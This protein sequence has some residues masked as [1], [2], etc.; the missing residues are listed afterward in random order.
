[1]TPF[2]G[3]GQRRSFISGDPD[4]SRLRVAYFE[5]PGS[6]RLFAK[7]WFGPGAEGPPGSA[8]GGAVMG[9]L[10]EVMGAA[11]WHQAL[12]VV[13]ARL[14]TNVRHKIPLGTDATCEG[15][16]AHIDGRKVTTHARMY[17]DA[18]RVLADAEGLFIILKPEQ[19]EA[20]EEHRKTT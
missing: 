17:D 5:K 18:H 2:P 9:V 3:L 10:D 7:A 12:P 16:I 4:G 8:H 15:W 14:T 11:C 1:M 13:L 20:F 19:I 6:T